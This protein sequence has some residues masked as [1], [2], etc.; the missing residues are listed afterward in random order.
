MYS[1]PSFQ[2]T[3]YFAPYYFFKKIYVSGLQTTFSFVEIQREIAAKAEMIIQRV[4]LNSRPGMY[5]SPLKKQCACSDCLV[6]RNGEGR[7]RH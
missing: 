3:E 2:I 6:L 1:I 7:N 5:F 4:V